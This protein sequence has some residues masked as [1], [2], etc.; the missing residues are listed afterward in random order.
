M[1]IW[2]M[3]IF[4]SLKK[5]MSQGPGILDFWKIN[6]EKIKFDELDFYS[7]SNFSACVAWKNQFQNWIL[8]AENPVR[9]NCFLQL[10][11]SKIKYRSTG[12]K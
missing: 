4:P 1:R 7:I 11:F 9:Q 10:D 5:R 2:D 12:S 6:L 8:Q 3:R